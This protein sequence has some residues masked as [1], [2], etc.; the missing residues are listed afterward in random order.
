VLIGRRPHCSFSPQYC[1]ASQ[2][3]SDKKGDWHDLCIGSH[4]HS[5][6][7]VSSGDINHVTPLRLLLIILPA[8]AR[9]SETMETTAI[10]SGFD[11]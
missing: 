10:V 5:L 11:T 3:Q 6:L 4:S 9:T 1:A 7:I 8:M 2:C